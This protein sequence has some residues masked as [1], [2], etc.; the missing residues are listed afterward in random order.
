MID[1]ALRAAIDRMAALPAVLFASD[2]DGVLSPIVSDPA[3]AAPHPEA[4]PAVE[5]AALLDDVEVVI[6][7]GRSHDVLAEL[8]GSPAGVTLI[9]THGAHH[10]DAIDPEL[11]HRVATAVT[12]LRAVEQEF[13]G[14]LVEP[15]PVGAALH[16][17]NATD[18]AG[19]SEAAQQV[20]ADGGARTI[21]GKAV[22]ELVLADGDKGTAIESI[23][24][25]TGADGVIYLGDDT[26]DED[27]FIRLRRTDVGVKVG[28]GPTA[29]AHRI[30]D[31]D[32]VIELIRSFIAAREAIS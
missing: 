29:A 5:H 9:G 4:I 24:T 7:S 27:V 18:P 31:P 28:P 26:T 22:V 12:A 14:S 23:R 13:E 15:K 6:I 3:A 2:F 19:A 32:E 16:Y 11:Q 21:L 10:G 8:T 17:R 1:Q 25:S 20:A 30:D